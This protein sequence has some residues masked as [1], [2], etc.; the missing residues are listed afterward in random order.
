MPMSSPTERKRT[1]NELTN[2]V[3]KCDGETTLQKVCVFLDNNRD[4]LK[5]L[6][7][8][9]VTVDNGNYKSSEEFSMSFDE[10][11][12]NLFDLDI[13]THYEVE[14]VW[15]SEKS[16]WCDENPDAFDGDH[17]V[18]NIRNND[19][20]SEKKRK[21]EQNVVDEFNAAVEELMNEG[22]TRMEA[23]NEVMDRLLKTGSLE[24]IS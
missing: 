12:T 17:L 1:M 6:A 23:T 9:V 11:V 16:D 13:S 5:K 22:K 8:V 2:E 14:A 20:D 15:I 24:K 3:M 19:K 21:D 7:G 4:W 10:A 18:L